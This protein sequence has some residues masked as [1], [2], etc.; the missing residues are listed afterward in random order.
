MDESTPNDGD[1]RGDETEPDDPRIP[2]HTAELPAAD[3]GTNGDDF[4]TTDRSDETGARSR[5]RRRRT[6]RPPSGFKQHRRKRYPRLRKIVKRTG[7]VFVVL[8]LSL[9]TFVVWSMRRPLPAINGEIAIPGLVGE[10]TVIRD[11]QGIPHI[12]AEN[13]DDLF[14]A[15]GY[16]QAQ[17]RFWQMDF[18][19]HISSGSLSEMFG[20]SQVDADEFLRTM[21]WRQLAE[22]QYAESSSLSKRALDGYTAGVNAY[23]ADRSPAELDFGYTVLEL[24]N[25]SYSP[26]PW[27]P[28]DSLAW[29]KV[30]AWD[31][32]GNMGNE[33]AR[34]LLLDQY[35]PEQVQQLF[36]DYPDENPIIIGDT[37]G[38]R[39][40]A[41]GIDPGPVRIVDALEDVVA[42]TQTLDDLTKGGTPGV[43]S[44]SWVIGGDRSATG[45]PILANDPHLGIQMPSIW[46][47]VGLHCAP[48]T[49]ACP[50]DVAGFSFPGV[51][52]V[53]IGHNSRIAWGLT[54]LGPDV[55]DLVV[56]QINPDNAN[57]YR[58]NDEWVNME[59]RT[60]TISVAGGENKTLTIRSTRNGPIISGVFG[61]LDNFD[62]TSGI[63]L[64]ENYAIAMR[65]TALLPS[66]G[67][68]ETLLRLNTASNF[69]EFRDA[70][71]YFA[72]PSQNM[73]YADVEG[74]IGYQSPGMIPIRRN[75][76]GRLPVPGW[77]DDYNWDGFIPFDDLPTLYNPDAGYIV[78]ANNPVVDGRFDYLLTT[79]WTYG[80]RARRLVDLISANQPLSVDD[81]ALIQFDAY[82]LNAEA[83]RP[84]VLQAINTDTAVEREAR[85]ILAEWNLQNRADSS[86][87][88]IWAAIWRSMLALTFQDELPESLWPAGGSRWF[89]V[90]DALMETPTDPF[91][92]DRT[93]SMIENRD[94]IL[95]R[96]F[97]NA[98][99]ELSDRLG[100]RPTTWKWGDLHEA[101]FR[102]PTLG[103]SGI[104][105]IEDRFNRGGFPTSGGESIVNATGWSPV[106]GY[107]V[108]WLP[109]MRMIVD[110]AN[111]ENSRAIHTTGQSGQISSKHY[112]DMAAVWAAGG[113]FPMRW[114]RGTI[115]KSS[116]GTLRL[117]P[118]P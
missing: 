44:N 57:Q 74:N 115:E 16:V 49:D 100:D 59:V 97:E 99:A 105:L 26:S 98:V 20:S 96:A 73:I 11:E 94:D 88:A 21:G 93:T 83:L 3:N 46:Y 86:G 80:Y 30:M 85:A 108:D 48:V 32:R 53:V 35:T 52:G 22:T 14:L 40:S 78:T 2:D 92:D 51:P 25:R 17:D 4:F 114:D 107:K 65:W 68:T 72:V 31:L 82:N 111:L 8:V 95:A 101:D 61:D 58:V 1:S 81:M 106:D 87:A 118:A 54:N 64:P 19:R 7:I 84:D 5:L 56:E 38:T 36:P 41:I 45:A 15:Q 29:G 27:S 104:G 110:L 47:Q 63:P 34:S 67:I 23:L 89:V 43:G 69:D 66:P 71:S 50:Y 113:N 103:E 76:D 62:E 28:V 109:S 112:I 39:T 90:M 33:I 117:V 116:E 24:S 77:I 60:E 102:N 37:S 42:L 70:L 91:W 75:G 55:V 18:W 10:V 9:V 6:A 12:Y 13:V 79:D